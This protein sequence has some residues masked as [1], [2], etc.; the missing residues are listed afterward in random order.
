MFNRWQNAVLADGRATT[1]TVV[2]A[3]HVDRVH[4]HCPASPGA[5]PRRFD[6]S[7]RSRIVLDLP[8]LVSTIL[9]GTE[10]DAAAGGP[11]T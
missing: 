11:D 7:D 10:R 5:T 3:S 8:A 4:L 2:D 6:E 9:A 1:G